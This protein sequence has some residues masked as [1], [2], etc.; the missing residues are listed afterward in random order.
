[1]KKQAGIIP[2]ILIVAVAISALIGGWVGFQI[3]DGTFFSFGVGFGV[4]FVIFLLLSP[5]IDSIKETIRKI[6][7]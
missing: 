1:M 2:V 6:R 7:N 3:G 4:V 5:H